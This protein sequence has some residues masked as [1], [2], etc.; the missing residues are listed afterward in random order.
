MDSASE[1]RVQDKLFT[2]LTNYKMQFKSMRKRT[3][4]NYING[5]IL[6]NKDQD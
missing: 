3:V 5:H 1:D 4:F 2:L 6:E